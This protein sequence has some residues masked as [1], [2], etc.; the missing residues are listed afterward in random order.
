MVLDSARPQLSERPAPFAPVNP[1]G[2]ASGALH[3]A[4]AFRVT[5]AEPGAGGLIG[6]SNFAASQI[7]M[8]PLERARLRVRIVGG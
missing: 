5:G 1:S 8:A 2:F 6:S 4:P 3:F 7:V